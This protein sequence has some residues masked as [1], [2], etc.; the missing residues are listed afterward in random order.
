ME[1]PR[2]SITAFRTALLAVLITIVYLAT[3]QSDYPIVENINDKAGHIVAF[4]VLAFLADFSFPKDN[5][6]ISK[7]LPFMGYGL[8]IDRGHSVFHSLPNVFILRFSC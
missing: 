5:F 7:V 1:L 2:G 4:C 8:L 6:S 3:T